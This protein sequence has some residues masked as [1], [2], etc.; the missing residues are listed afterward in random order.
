MKLFYIFLFIS[1]TIF[2]EEYIQDDLV[3][4]INRFKGKKVYISTEKGSAIIEIKGK[5]Y[6]SQEIKEGMVQSIKISGDK[7]DYRGK[8]AKEI[9]LYKGSPE[10]VIKI[11]LDGKKFSRYRGDFKFVSYKGNILPLNSIQSE[12]YIYSVVPSEIGHYFPKEA[13]K[14]QTLAARSYLYYGLKYSRYKGFDLYDN[15]NSQMYLGMD[16]ENKQINEIVRKTQGE[17]I[18]YKGN[19]INALYY[20]TSG[21]VTANSEDVWGG[22]KVPY[23]RS[24]RDKGNEKRSPRLNWTVKISKNEVSKKFGYRVKSLKVMEVK[25]N[26]VSKIR[27]SGS[28]TKT[29]SGDKL[30][31]IIG[32]GKLYSTQFKVK[33][34]GNYFVFTGK[35]SGHGVGMSQYGAYGLSEK[36]KDYEQILRHYYKGVEIKE[37]NRE[38]KK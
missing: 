15:V 29:I 2:G 12:D 34:S 26:R 30:R 20:S 33:S 25:S 17:A 23:L 28:K 5:N 32:Y 21:G 19:P 22:V 3:V 8:K 6:Y 10:S 36:G 38:S 1:L 24:V 27:V 14:A 4:G 18:L 13:I 16:R 35:G 7:V 37:Y 11:S 9:Y 31:S